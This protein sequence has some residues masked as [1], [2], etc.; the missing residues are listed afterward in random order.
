MTYVTRTIIGRTAYGAGC[1]L[2]TLAR[3]PTAESSAGDS[4]PV[5]LAT[6]PARPRLHSRASYSGRDV[7]GESLHAGDLAAAVA[8]LDADVV[9]VQEVDVGRPR[10]HGVDQP[11]VVA[12]ALGATDWRFA[13]TILGT[14]ARDPARS[15]M[16]IEPAV[17]RSPDGAASGPRYGVAL[18]SRIP[19]RRWRCPTAPPAQEAYSSAWRRPLTEPDDRCCSCTA[20]RTTDWPGKQL[21]SDLVDD[22]RLVAMDLRGH[23]ESDRPPMPTTTR[24]RGRRTWK[25]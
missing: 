12:A 1:S 21:H 16:P 14:P 11:A 18:F 15:W 20:S 24:L 17:L 5:P 9:A 3:R 25:P 23:G 13:T 19:V 4:N 7:T 2:T 22:H 6:R 8:E 10:S